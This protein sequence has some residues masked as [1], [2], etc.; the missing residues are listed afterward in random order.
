[1][2]FTLSNKRRSCSKWISAQLLATSLLGVVSTGAHGFEF[3]WNPMDWFGSDQSG[4][5]RTVSASAPKP[6]DMPHSIE[7]L[8]YG[9]LLFDFY[10]QHYFSAI[11]KILMAKEKGMLDGNKEHAELVL[12]SLYVSYGM[13]DA[14][15]AIF[16]QL[17]ETYTSN[18]AAD[19]AWYQMA[20][21]FYKKGLYQRALDTLQTKI[22]EPLESRKTEHVLLQ[23]LSHIQLTQ[24]DE[25]QSAAKFLQSE[26][27]LSLFIRFNLGS[28]FA[29]LW[30]EEQASLHYQYII[31]Q[32]ATTE[33]DK[34]L[35]DQAALALGIFYLQDEEYTK[36]IEVLRLIRL[37]GPVANRGL[38]ALG[39]AHFYSGQLKQALTPWM[40]LNDRP[41]SSP[42]VQES[43]LNVPYVYE[44][45]DALQDALDG[46]N[47]AYK[48]LRV[49]RR[50]LEDIKSNIMKPG[51]ME[52]ISPVDLSAQSVM[53]SARDFQLPVEDDATPHLYLYFA[54][55]EFQRLYRDYRELQRL[56]M[57][58]IH[59]ERQLPSLNQMIDT[60]VERLDELAP[61]SQQ[62]V[63]QSQN[64][65]AY[66]KVKLDEFKNRLAE[67]IRNDDLM[68]LASAEQL[69]QKA[70]LDF[71]ET[72][73]TQLNDEDL[74]YEEWSKL[75]LLKGLLEWDLNAT[76]VDRRW[77][78]SKDQATIENLLTELEQSIVRV[79]DAREIRLSRFTG[80]E[81]RILQIKEQVDA[82]QD[83]IAGALRNQ[84]GHLQSV[85]VGIIDQKQKQLDHMRAKTLFAIARLQDKGY[86]Q[87]R[88][89]QQKQAESVTFELGKEPEPE[90]ALE[91]ETTENQ[92]EASRHLGDVIR[93]I[94]KN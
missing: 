76:V 67:I 52:K 3:N 30:N 11:T 38:L 39:W 12:G 19:E 51:W 25:A 2:N 42:S 48:T 92:E 4:Q 85:A 37:H 18:E 59:W 23:V 50:N 21:I 80:F 24:L 81:Q 74:Y 5:A 65:Y 8:A 77:Q 87:E 73:L 53:T 55:N 68:G 6:I 61:Q 70:R 10:Q 20:R 79:A 14:G 83:E 60:N 44:K 72:T 29:Q 66:S 36:A 47:A 88:K 93:K 33:L 49:Q 69:T 90:E 71:I 45:L 46:Y 86:M 40:E 82:L 54:S 34:T 22:V 91:S 9:D 1:M 41:L 17:L 78:A 27:D 32:P 26:E 28:A 64:F 94:F 13:L 62:A 84:R 7:D 57:V 58:L 56:Y 89:R 35:R 15:E 43:I 63:Q 31:D 16:N 75:R